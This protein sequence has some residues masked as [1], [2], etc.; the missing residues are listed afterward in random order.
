MATHAGVRVPWSRLVGACLVA[1]AVWCALDPNWPVALQSTGR[2]SARNSARLLP[3]PL[4]PRGPVRGA[5][6]EFVWEWDGPE[7]DWR[8]V[9]LDADLHPVHREEVGAVRRV[10]VQGRLRRLLARGGEFQ[11]FVEST[12]D[13]RHVH[14]A[15]VLFE[16]R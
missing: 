11:W 10:P 7:L 6:R 3:R 2:T 15:P 5:V 12:L 1:V 14:S 9:V 8:L 4:S 16:V 13:G